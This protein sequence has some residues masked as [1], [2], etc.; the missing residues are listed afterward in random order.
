[1]PQPLEP[2]V[3][4]WHCN[5]E[6]LP[7]E[8][9]DELLAVP[10][11]VG[12]P[13]AMEAL[14]FGL[15]CDAEGQN[16]FVRGLVGT[17]RM[18]LLGQLL[19]ELEPAARPRRSY[20][21][22]HNFTDPD[23]PRLI[24]LP[25]GQGRPFRRRVTDLAEFIRD[26]LTEAVN[27][28]PT[29]SRRE[30]IER[31]AREEGN[32]LTQPFGR[33][34]REA[35]LE[36]VSLQVGPV[37]Q[38]AILPVVEG[39]PVPPEEFEQM[40][41]QGQVSEDQVK[42]YRAQRERFLERLADISAMVREI[43]SRSAEAVRA[44]IGEAVREI[45]GGLVEAIRADFP[46]DD[47]A[48]F[49]HQVIDDVAENRLTDFGQKGFDPLRLYGVNVVLDHGAG[50]G[51]AVV[52]EHTPTLTKLLGS[53]EREW[54]AQGPTASDHR[55][56]RAGSLLRADGGYLVLE[57]RDV[58][59]E[60]GAWKV[61]IRTLRT[62]FLE[63]VP[64]E[65]AFPFLQQPIKPEPIPIRLRVILLGDAQTYSLLDRYD[66]D[67]PHL[68]KVLADFDSVID[69]TPDSVRQ[70][71][72]VLAR[73]AHDEKLPP[74]QRSAVA[75]L[76]EHGARIAA[77]RG[78]L[79]ARFGRIADLAR[80]AAFIAHKAENH[81]VTGE[82]VTLAIQRTRRRAD[83]PARR[84]REA[85]REGTLNIEVSG[86]VVGQVNG[87]AVTHSGPLTY[88]FPARITASIGAGS[89]GLVN[90]DIQSALSGA[91]HTKGFHILGGLLRH[92]LQTDHP[93]AFS[94]SLAFEQSYGG[95]DGDSASCAEICCL[96]SALT[97]VP[98]RQGVAITGAI[99]Q[100][101]KVQAIGGVNEKI[102]GFFAACSELGLDGSQGVIIPLANA[103]D[104]MLRT[105]V[106]EACRAGRFRVWAVATV[107]EALELLTGVPAGQRG[108][109]GTYPEGTLLRTAMERAREFWLKVRQRS[110]SGTSVGDVGPDQ[111]GE[112]GS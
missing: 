33:E 24:T 64:A 59:T 81:T 20:C 37:A 90:I 102:E 40:A 7:F 67:F 72:G 9:T 17:G 52:I 104:L 91:I 87:L 49:L 36:L 6:D 68:F 63:I 19:E 18:T 4:R 100:L 1:M 15:E 8:R 62:G 57:A 21:Y 30:A 25:P 27:A 47:V 61:L 11:F 109:D 108:V 41:A 79:T 89:A 45:L 55:A 93:L 77:Q 53:V 101:G 31:Q 111:A 14:R 34:L 28:E 66:P 103:G 98:L 82:E 74:F 110:E 43:Q 85:L 84:F 32:A 42:A 94:A 56:I 5:P 105:E 26:R 48:A 38:P 54:N 83:L 35:N 58:L 44:V 95:I 76:V 16:V 60:P 73:L 69:R 3:L 29:R 46:G 96:L 78:K 75:A 2:S 99:D 97:G 13:T 86:E 51:S 107:H 23:R 70:Y 106:V 22:V 50:E 10:T 88:G 39:R 92:L 65:L 112:G 12:Q 71:A 80:E